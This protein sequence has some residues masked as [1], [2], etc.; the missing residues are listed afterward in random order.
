MR[1]R[2]V[3]EQVPY[4][5]ESGHDEPFAATHSATPRVRTRE[6]TQ[7]RLSMLGV[8]SETFS[9]VSD[10]LRP[11]FRA[12]VACSLRMGMSGSPA[13]PTTVTL[14]SSSRGVPVAPP[15]SRP[16]KRLSGTVTSRAVTSICA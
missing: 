15:S 3:S 2:G 14:R 13:P 7:A 8:T 16:P 4:V 5:Q 6:L 9:N 10:T 12:R 1:G 11:S